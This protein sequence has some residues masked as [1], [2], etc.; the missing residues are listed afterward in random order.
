MS[1]PS[2]TRSRT[3]QTDYIP[4]PG[5]PQVCSRPWCKEPA[6][7]GDGTEADYCSSHAEAIQRLRAQLAPWKPTRGDRAGTYYPREPRV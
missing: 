5:R 2:I 4:V 7:G 6:I 1:H 3:Y